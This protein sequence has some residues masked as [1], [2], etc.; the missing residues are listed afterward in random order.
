MIKSEQSFGFARQVSWLALSLILSAGARAADDEA[1]R[2]NMVIVLADDLGWGDVGYNGHPVVQTPALDRLARDGVRLDRFYA[3]AASCSPTRASALTGRNGHRFGVIR[4]NNGRM[5]PGERTIAE[6]LRDHG[7]ATGH[8]GKWHLGTLVEGRRDGQRGGTARGEGF[9]SPPWENGFDVCF[10]T[11]SKTPTWNPMER[12]DNEVRTYWVPRSPSDDRKGWIDYGTAYWV[13]VNQ[14][15]GGNLEGDDS[16]IIMD[17]VLPFVREAVARE[18]PFLA[19]VWFHAP[20]MPVVAGP[21]FTQLYPGRAGFEQHYYGAITAM[22]AQIG[23]LRA[24]LEAAGVWDDTLLVFGSD[25]GPESIDHSE[26][27]PAPGSAG[28]LR[29]RKRSLHEGGVRVPGIV[30][31]PAGLAGGRVS[32]L[33]F[34]TSDW[35]PSIAGLLGEGDAP[36][37]APIDGCDALSLLRAGEER[38]PKPIPFEFV[39]QVSLL[40]NDWKLY[41]GDDGRTFQLYHLST[42]P[43]ESRDVAAR[44]PERVARMRR[45][46]ETWRESCRLSATGADYR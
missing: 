31:W 38:R 42:D 22:D 10:S 2:P 28:I 12:P 3:Q 32:S 25:N 40:D 44:H 7:Y 29:G 1:G 43:A 14:P 17:R 33:P 39:G 24:A 35:L 18:Q 4:A 5:E 9:Y 27:E 23:R 11:E 15:A 8:F 6:L 21:E 37:V 16:R 46:L 13:G 19:V 36:A 30:S 20:H 34:T 45:E 26:M 41:S